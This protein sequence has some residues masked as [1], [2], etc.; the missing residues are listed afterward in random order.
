M[1]SG[2]ANHC[3]LEKTQFI[4]DGHTMDLLFDLENATT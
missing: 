3:V 2:C 1:M 4:D